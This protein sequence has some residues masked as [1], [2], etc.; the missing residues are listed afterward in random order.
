MR[1]PSRAR[2]HRDA[3]AHACSHREASVIVLG[4]PAQQRLIN[5]HHRQRPA[6]LSCRC[7]VEVESQ[8]L[9]VAGGTSGPDPSKSRKAGLAD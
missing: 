5:L 4:T 2:A 9:A 7:V 1:S 8:S 3:C 6:E